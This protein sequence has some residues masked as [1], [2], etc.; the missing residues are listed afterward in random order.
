MI[1]LFKEISFRFKRFIKISYT[2]KC[3]KDSL[4]LVG[5]NS[6]NKE[7]HMEKSLD[8]N[9][10]VANI[11]SNMTNMEDGLMSRAKFMIVRDTWLKKNFRR[12][13][14]IKMTVTLLT[15]I[16]LTISNRCSFK[17]NKALLET[18]KNLKIN[19]LSPKQ[20]NLI[21]MLI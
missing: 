5:N 6:L 20:K 9:F 1:K 14:M 7:T 17:N 18:K 3:K 12:M 21:W 16:L 10:Q 19:L 2:L 11:C 13:S 15:M 4:I 8:L